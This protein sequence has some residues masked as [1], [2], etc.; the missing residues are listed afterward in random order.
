MQKDSFAN[1]F[2]DCHLL[3]RIQKR[4]RVNTRENSSRILERIVLCIQKVYTTTV[5]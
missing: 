3:R 4:N 5:Y 1:N 2:I